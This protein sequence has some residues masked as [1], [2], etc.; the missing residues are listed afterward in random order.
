M[1]PN[2]QTKTDS[3]NKKCGSGRLLASGELVP[4]TLTLTPA[5]H[6]R[7]SFNKNSISAHRDT[8]DGATGLPFVVFHDLIEE[9]DIQLAVLKQLGRDEE[10]SPHG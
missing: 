2:Q 4:D 6:R 1:D 9:K 3:V 8:P 7:T 5:K 10:V